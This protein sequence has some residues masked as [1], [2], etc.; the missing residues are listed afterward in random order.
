MLQGQRVV[1]RAWQAADVEPLGVLRNDVALQ[2]QLM[3]QPRPNTPE[4]V[5]AWLKARSEQSDGVFFVIADRQTDQALGFIQLQHLDLFHGHADLGICLAPE[6]QG[7]GRGREA[8]QLLMGYARSVFSLR[9]ILLQVLLSNT[10]AIAL[11]E[12]LGFERVGVLK[13]HFCAQGQHHDV[14]WMEHLT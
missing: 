8:M 3:S 7:G 11:Y 4:R 10:R 1:L 12:S 13:A 14:L 6:A 5:Q 2:Q 9:K